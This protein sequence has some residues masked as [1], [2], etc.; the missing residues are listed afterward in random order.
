MS[1][2]MDQVSAQPAAEQSEDEVMAALVAGYNGTT[3]R[4]EQPP[5]DPQPEAESETPEPQGNVPSP[6]PVEEKPEQ[7]GIS[8][9]TE[10]LKTLREKVK[11]T[12]GDADVIRRMHGEIGNINRTLTQLQ[13]SQEQATAKP[14][15]A[16]AE[17]EFAAALTQAEKVADEFP[18]LAGP[19]VKVI[20]TMKDRMAQTTQPAEPVDVHALVTNEISKLRQQDE[21]DA[22]SDLLADHPDYTT[23]RETAEYKA[24]LSSKTP[25]FQKRFTTTWNPAVVSK[26]LTEFKDSMKTKEQPAAQAKPD[27]IKRLEAAVAPQGVPHKP[28]PSTISDEEALLR[29]YNSG[30]KRQIMRR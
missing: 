26:G 21:E 5:A 7:P 4:G 6:D 20:K 16:P 10:E 15:Q 3:A 30:P 24:W 27:K 8:A 22:K 12:A 13:K 11:T 18:E 9:L 29:G 25:E 28:Q 2:V 19:L 14:E 23:V 17:D 1:E